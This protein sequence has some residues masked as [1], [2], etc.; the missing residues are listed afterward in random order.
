MF[1]AAQGLGAATGNI[2]CCSVRPPK[3]RQRKPK[4]R[5]A[6]SIAHRR[7]GV[8]FYPELYPSI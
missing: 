4:L 3:R 1:Y 7:I 6:Y 8:A 2:S 5:I